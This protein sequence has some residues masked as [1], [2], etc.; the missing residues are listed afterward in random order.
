MWEAIA[1]TCMQVRLMMNSR[2][3]QRYGQDLTGEAGIKEVRYFLTFRADRSSSSRLSL[4]RGGFLCV[5][6]SNVHG[7]AIDHAQED[8]WYCAQFTRRSR[9]GR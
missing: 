8:G 7:K 4:A 2:P 5:V 1:G 3:Q 9:R 6:I